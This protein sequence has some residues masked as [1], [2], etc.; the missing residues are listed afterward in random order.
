MINVGC[1]IGKSNLNVFFANRNRRFKNDEEGINKFVKICKGN[2]E[3]R[4]ILEPSGGYER[5]LVKQLFENKVKL[6]V[7][8]P[9][10]VR[11]FARS[12]K[13]LAK[14]DKIDSKVL[15]EYGEKMDPRIQ[16]EKEGYLFELEE[17]TG[18]RDTLV[19]TAQ[20]E[21]LR[22]E[23]GVSENIEKSI[24]NHLIFLKESI[25]ELEE[26]IKVIVEENAQE[27][28]EILRSENGIGA[29]TTAILLGS[30]PELGKLD[31]RQIT[32]LAGLAPMAHDSG[33]MQN[34]R[35]IRGG[36]GRIRKALFM[37]SIS[38]IRSNP[39]VADFYNRLKSNGKPTHVALT[40]VAHKLLI[41]LNSKMRNF[42]DGKNIF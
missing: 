13:D 17:L 16:E 32:K 22:L 30:L 36:R 1:D 41:I 11:N 3:I 9:Y 8:N 40:A 20:E 27:K 37:S 5:K 14:T 31:N 7:V 15:S 24:N 38:A 10:Y 26:K 42:Y 21:K 4:V 25:K 19:E 28:A 39:K 33:K 23:K 29:Q 18:R 35:H 2:P 34:R 12:F 6:S